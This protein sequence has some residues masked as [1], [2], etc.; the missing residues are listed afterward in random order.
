MIIGLIALAA[1]LVLGTTRV[2]ERS[3]D[4]QLAPLLTRQ[5]G[6]PVTLAPIEVDILGLRARSAR[7]VMGESANPAI[8]A[9]EVEVDLTWGDLLTGEIRL[10]TVQAADLTVSLSNWPRS[11]DPLPAD[12]HFL[13]PWLP[14]TLHLRAGRYVPA[15]GTPWPLRQ[16]LWQRHP[17]NSATL[18]WSEDRPSGE[19]E[20]RAR[21]ASLPA[22]LGLERLE[23]GM[24]LAAPRRV[25]D[26]GVLEVSVQA[27]GDTGYQ[28]RDSALAWL[29]WRSVRSFLDAWQTNMGD[30]R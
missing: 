15:T 14:Q 2:V 5:L 11:D 10:E 26:G 25:S 8:E 23:L 18:T 1:A 13:E 24:E 9:S 19:I 6:L 3:L 20:L 22:L 16:L 30:G 28:L 29:A 4:R 17:D 12:Y 21:L 27:S 7:L